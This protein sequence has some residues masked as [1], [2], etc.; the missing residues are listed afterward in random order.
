M[1]STHEAIKAM[2][3]AFNNLLIERAIA[4]GDL[5]KEE[6]ETQINAS[7]RP[8][9]LLCDEIWDILDE[10]GHGTPVL[11]H[12]RDKAS[13]VII[14]DRYASQNENIKV[15]NHIYEAIEAGCL[16][17]VNGTDIFDLY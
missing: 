7:G 5:F 10:S 15:M 16:V 9:Y 6:E 12:H 14:Y 1:A 4:E 8:E 2:Y 17:T 3:E 13:E 11:I